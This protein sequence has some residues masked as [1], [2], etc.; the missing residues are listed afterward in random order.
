MR[1]ANELDPLEVDRSHGEAVVHEADDAR[2]HLVAELGQ[3]VAEE[4]GEVDAP[5]S[6]PGIGDV[7]RPTDVDLLDD[8]ARALERVRGRARRRL[9]PR[10]RSRRSRGRRRVRAACPRRTRQAGRERS[11]GGAS[12][13][14]VALVGSLG[15]PRGTAARRPRCGRAGRSAGSCRTGWGGSRAGCGRSSASAR[16]CRTTRPGCGPSRPCR[17]PRRAERSRTPPPRPTPPEEPP[18]VRCEVPGVA[19]HAP[20]RAV[21]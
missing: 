14:D 21:A 17:C 5:V 9:R 18:G 15:A 20:E 19:G 11:S 4:G 13:M 10:G 16:R 7:A 12:D 6:D 3:L 1:G 2:I 8:G